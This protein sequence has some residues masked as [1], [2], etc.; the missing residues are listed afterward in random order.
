MPY[1][2]KQVIADRNL[3]IESGK[4]AQQADSSITVRYGN[5]V[6]LVT[7]CAK[8]EPEESKLDFIP[9]T[10]D[11]EEKLYAAG[12]IP[13]SF[14]RREGRPSE[15]AILN[16][17]LIDRSIRPLLS[18]DFNH[19]VQVIA[20]VLSADRENNPNTC[21]LIGT[22]AALTI[23]DIPFYKPISGVHVGYI[24]NNM[25]LNPTFTQVEDSLFD[26]MLL[27]YG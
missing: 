5:T 15:E 13:G 21:A 23:S 20:A 26:V 25:I 18:K 24:D 8:N 11:Y 9:L 19:Q 3:I 4:L 2:V 12:K 14:F 7:V 1:T 10:V 17:R 6:T 22:S 27:V 16:S